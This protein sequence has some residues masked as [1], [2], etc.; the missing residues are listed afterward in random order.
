MKIQYLLLIAP[1]FIAL[2]FYGYSWIA[3]LMRQPSD[4][5]VFLGVSLTGILITVNYIFFRY[6][7]KKF[8]QAKNPK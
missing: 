3:D 2:D 1:L 4:V 8:K 7:I 5:T 6:L